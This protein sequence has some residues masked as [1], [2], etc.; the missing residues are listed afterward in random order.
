MDKRWIQA[1]KEW[2]QVGKEWINVGKQWRNVTV[3][4]LTLKIIVQALIDC[5]FDSLID[6]LGIGLLTLNYMIYQSTM[7]PPLLRNAWQFIR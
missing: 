3:W 2:I 5:L 6:I 7:R 1:G 4:C